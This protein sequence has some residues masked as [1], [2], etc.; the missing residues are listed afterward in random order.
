MYFYGYIFGRQY[1]RHL[2]RVLNGKVPSLDTAKLTKEIKEQAKEVMEKERFS[3][4][5]R[6]AYL[7]LTLCAY[8]LASFQRVRKRSSSSEE[9]FECV[10]IA[11]CKTFQTPYQFLTRIYLMVHKDPFHALSKYSMPEINYKLFGS[12]MCFEERKN[13]NQI[14]LIVTRCAFHSFF[15]RYGEPQLTRLFCEWDRNWMDVANAS[16]RPIRVDRP[17]ALSMGDDQCIFQFV[18]DESTQKNENDVVFNLSKNPE[19]KEGDTSSISSNL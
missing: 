8:V 17:S 15:E 11:F 3:I 16:S 13:D 2:S 12:S 7:I 1:L 6:Q 14:D 10:R 9:T 5:D 4:P 18:Y 19:G